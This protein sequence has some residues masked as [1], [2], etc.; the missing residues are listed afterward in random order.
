MCANPFLESSY[1]ILDG[2]SGLAHFFKK[3]ND[4]IPYQSLSMAKGQIVEGPAECTLSSKTKDTK[5]CFTWQF[6]QSNGKDKG[7]P[8]F[9][10]TEQAGEIEI[11][12]SA[13]MHCG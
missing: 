8:M 3:E 9:V 2:D 7:K 11:M 10:C 12:R 6:K 5:P 1:F 4:T 13:F